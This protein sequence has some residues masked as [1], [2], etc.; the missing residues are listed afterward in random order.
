MP[1]AHANGEVA[2]VTGVRRV[3]R[4]GQAVVGAAGEQVALGLRAPG[5]GDDHRERGVAAT[6]RVTASPPSS[7]GVSMA[8]RVASRTAPPRGTRGHPARRRRGHDRR[9]VGGDD[10]A[11][12]VHDDQRAHHDVTVPRRRA[13]DPAGGAVLAP[14]PLRHARA[15]AG[16]DPPGD[17]GWRVGPRWAG[18]GGCRARHGPR[19]GR[20]AR[21]PR[22]GGRRWPP[23]GRSAPAPHGSG[24]PRPCSASARI[25]PSAA[26]R[27]NAE[28]PVSTIASTCSTLANGSSTAVS[29]VAGAPPRIST[30]PTVSGGS[31]T[32]VTPVAVPVQCPARTPGTSV[33]TSARSRR[34]AA[35]AC[36]SPPW[37]SLVCVLRAKSMMSAS[38]SSVR[39]YISM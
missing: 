30:E 17:E 28:P 10:V 6:G 35:S 22:P 39:S 34:R 12:R 24:S 5:I 36:S 3:D 27:P 23:R 4:A 13:P 18:Q 38:T 14:A 25:T 19:R 32:T 1:V 9:A 16:A 7:G 20:G 33:I 2:V 29:R 15:A 21:R 11:D 37:R 31:T 26:A 8:L